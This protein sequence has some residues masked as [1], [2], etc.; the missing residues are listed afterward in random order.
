MKLLRLTFLAATL[1]MATTDSLAQKQGW[2]LVWHDE[3]DTDG[4]PNSEIW[5]YEHGF[6]RNHEDQ[7]YQE[8]NVRCERGL[9]IFE[10]R[11]EKRP[12]P[13]YK[14]NSTDWRTMRDSIRYTSSCITTRGNFSF[15]YGRLE[16]RARIPVTGGAWPAIWTLGNE[17]EWPSNGEIDL[18]EFYRIGG[19]PHILANAAWGNDKHYDPI[20]NSRRVPFSHFLEKDPLW[21]SKF[22]I[23]R[24]DWDEEAIRMYI[25]DE[26]IN[27]IKMKDVRNGSI[28]NY[29][30]PF[31]K[32]QYIL[33][34]LAM[35]GD[36]GGEIDDLSLP[37]RYEV[38]YVRCYQKR[39][40]SLPKRR[41]AA[42]KRK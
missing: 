26:L 2:Q 34:N 33:L 35:G 25:D 14:K 18:M 24:M 31:D 28:G 4:K 11:A 7:W 29:E 8:D 13:L 9:L 39:Q 20:W 42:G 5:N 10:G 6:S 38:D 22:H 19:E 30:N 21:A 32:P 27:E 3:F 36:N 1:C 17:M 23:W 16:V 41:P 12:N 15:L 37:M 40:G